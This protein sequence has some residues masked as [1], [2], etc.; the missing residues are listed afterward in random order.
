MKWGIGLIVLSIFMFLFIL[1]PE[2][3]VFEVPE[4]AKT[5]ESLG[6]SETF[7]GDTTKYQTKN[8]ALNIAEPNETKM[9]IVTFRRDRYFYAGIYVNGLLAT[10]EVIKRGNSE[11]TMT[12]PEA[13]IKTGK[14]TIYL[15]FTDYLEQNK[16]SSYPLTIAPKSY[17]LYDYP[18]NR[19]TQTQVETQ[20]DSIA[21]SIIDSKKSSATSPE[22]TMEILKNQSDPNTLIF[23]GTAS[24]DSGIESVTVNG[25][26][27]G[28]ENWIAPIEVRG[29]NNYV[30]VIRDNGGNTTIQNISLSNPSSESN[31]N[32][33][34]IIAT[35][36]S[37]IIVTIG[38][39][40]A[41]IITTQKKKKKKQ[42]SNSKLTEG[43]KTGQNNKHKIKTAP[44][45]KKDQKKT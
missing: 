31:P 44:Q 9:L 3:A 24:S 43:G 5:F 4:G 28:T 1:M 13:F 27:A 34:L 12:I 6:L 18:P 35:I 30:V 2:T 23:S 22:I 45:S 16:F 25:Q 37:A 20:L 36:I 26:Y 7:N 8:V 21:F 38:T 15:E 10:E 14:N 11:T 40:G 32:Y 17:F 33:F 42:S 29:D 41:V 19:D 39:I